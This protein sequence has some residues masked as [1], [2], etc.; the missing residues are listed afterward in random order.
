GGTEL[1]TKIRSVLFDSDRPS[2]RTEALLFAA[3]RAHHVAP[4]V[5]PNL[6]EGNIVITDRYIDAPIAYQAAGRNF[7][8]KTILALRRCA[9]QGLVPQLTMLRDIAPEADRQRLGHQR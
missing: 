7:E 8:A 3:D 5:D 6:D 4:L 9:T 1:G 2:T